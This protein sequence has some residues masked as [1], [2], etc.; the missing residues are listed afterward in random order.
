MPMTSSWFSPT[1]GIREKP[2][3]RASESA[4]RSVLS[5]STKTM[6][7]R[8][9][10]TSRTIVSPSSNTEW[11][12]ARAPGSMTWRCSSRSTRPRSSSS[13]P[14]ASAGSPARG[15]H[16]AQGQ[17]QPREGP[18]DPGHGIQ[19][20]GRHQGHDALVLPAEDPRP[21]PGQDVQHGGHD[22][23]RSAGTR[24]SRCRASAPARRRPARWLRS[25]CRPGRAAARLG[26]GLARPARPGAGWRRGSGC[27]GGCGPVPLPRTGTRA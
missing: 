15:Q 2:L 7:V 13:V 5:R 11:I 8:G 3:R 18:E 12:M 9:T 24:A 22:R 16:A 6:S 20:V 17:Q 27:P 19:H 14:N 23:Q 4:W 1:T 21:D 26:T 10:I 25:H